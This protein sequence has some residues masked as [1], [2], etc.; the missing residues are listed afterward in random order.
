MATKTTTSNA[1]NNNDYNHNEGEDGVEFNT[2]TS[3]NQSVDQKEPTSLSNSSSYN[4]LDELPGKEY[5]KQCNI[6]DD[7]Y[8][9]IINDT[10]DKKIAIIMTIL[11]TGYLFPFES[12]LMSLDY[13]SYLYPEFKIYSTFPFVYMGAIALTFIAFLRFPN[14]SSHPKRMIIG[15]S[16]YLCIMVLVPVINLTPIGGSFASYII[17]LILMIMTGVV[18]GF[19]QGTVYAIAGLFG[20]QY[21]Q[22][23]QIG[24]GL[25]GII[26]AVT[27][28]FSK[29][30]FPQSPQG[31]KYGSLLYFLISAFVIFI[32]L[33]SFLYLLKLPVGKTI[34][35]KKK[36]EPK[37]KDSSIPFKTVFKSNIQ[38]GLINGYIFLISM[39][40]FPG[41]VL[42]IPAKVMRPD[43]FII[44]LLT[45][46]NVFDF[47]GKTAPIYFHPNGKRIP[48]KAL[49]WVITL[50]RSIFVALFFLC[51]YTKA[52]ESEAWPVI[53]LSIFGF[54]NG[55]VCSITFAEG[56]R[57]V[58]RDYKE[59]SGIFMTT[60][61]VIGLT[62]GSTLNF[63]V[64]YVQ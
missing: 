24:V 53:F 51:V 21:T 48:P 29:L 13:F 43:W 30:V 36:K 54:T 6:L 46:Y 47:F 9:P 14:F 49:L 52:F 28:I 4:Q 23:T 57:L 60:C 2:Y 8:L 38:L 22:F 27:R 33:L 10:L 18:D 5:K 58:K 31:M 37:S 19:V 1:L 64:T 35:A 25:A 61:L 20:P 63:I 3:D 50:G 34:S 56:P 12:F 17:T 11:G 55:Y 45:T 42:E 15:F 44:L 32:A 16:F 26:V 62:I 40:L 7:D 41:I 59:L 39:F